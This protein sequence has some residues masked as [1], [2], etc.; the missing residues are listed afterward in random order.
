MAKED[1]NKH[2]LDRGGSDQS[3][4]DF[5]RSN[6]YQ[7]SNHNERPGHGRRADPNEPQTDSNV[8]RNLSSEAEQELKQQH[9]GERRFNILVDSVP[10]LVKATPFTFNGEIRYRVSFNG[11]PE[12]VFTWDSSLGQLRAIDDD[13]ST[14]PDNLEEA[15]SEK[16]QSKT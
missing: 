4:K 1:K 10:Y 12:H 6:K 5:T 13:S 15:I 14:L 8:D 3:N 2:T 16:L 11:S 9:T 7:K